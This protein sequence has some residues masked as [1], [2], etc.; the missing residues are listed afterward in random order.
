MRLRGAD[1]E[2]HAAVRGVD[3][4]TVEALAGDVDLHVQDERGDMPAHAAAALRCSPNDDERRAAIIHVASAVIGGHPP[5]LRHLNFRGMAPLH[6]ALK[7]A[8]NPARDYRAP[9]PVEVTKLLARADPDAIRRPCAAWGGM[10]PLHMAVNQGAGELVA[11]FLDLAPEA[12]LVVDDKGRTPLHVAIEQHGTTCVR[13]LLLKHREALCVADRDG[14]TPLDSAALAASEVR[15]HI[16]LGDSR[17]RRSSLCGLGSAMDVLLQMVQAAD[18]D[19]VAR[20]CKSTPPAGEGTLHHFYAHPLCTAAWAGH[21]QLFDAVLAKAPEAV[22][23]R[24]ERGAHVLHFA[25]ET[26]QVELARRILAADPGAL[27]AE[28][29][30]D[31]DLPVHMAAMSGS[32]ELLQ[33]L[34]AADATIFDRV[35]DMNMVP[36]MRAIEAKRALAVDYILSCAPDTAGVEDDMGDAAVSYIMRDGE[37]HR[38]P[39]LRCLLK[40]A[41]GAVWLANLKDWNVLHMAAHYGYADVLALLWR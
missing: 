5:A 2:L 11:L 29:L 22:R 23:I 14:C 20:V 40:H 38:L 41:P 15:G 24:S 10:T 25:C 18:D 6:V 7:S 3:V 9:A 19:G 35:N 12:A 36:V 4:P 26:G 32:V 34:R 37:E 30:A 31:H 1:D 39:L 33:V 27:Y 16:V 8:F 17:R 13:L 28:E 21:R